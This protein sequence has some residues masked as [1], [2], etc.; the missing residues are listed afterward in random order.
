M[1]ESEV[2]NDS[3]DSKTYDYSMQNDKNQNIR[4]VIV[5]KK[6][7]VFDSNPETDNIN[8]YDQNE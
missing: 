5:Q 6:E 8:L 2:K 4:R 1:K 7:T 3:R